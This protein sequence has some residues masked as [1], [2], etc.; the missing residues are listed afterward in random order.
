M[1]PP[2]L[3]WLSTTLAKGANLRPLS[4]D[5]LRA[6]AGSAMRVTV[7]AAYWD[8]RFLTS[9]FDSIPADRRGKATIR[10]F[11]N[12]FTGLRGDHDKK[13]L[14]ALAR[15]WH[16]LGLRNLD[17]HLITGGRLFHAKVLLFEASKEVC[18]LV[19]SANATEAAFSDN[20]EMMLMLRAAQVPPGLEQYLGE[21]EAAATPLDD[22]RPFEART[23]ASFFRMGS[24]YYK[25]TVGTQFRF[26]LRLPPAM[27]AAM[28]TLQVPIP[29]MTARASQTYNPFVEVGLSAEQE[30]ELAEF[31]EADDASSGRARVSLRNYGVQTCYGWWVPNAYDEELKRRLEPVR[32]QRSVTLDR[33]SNLLENAG[34]IIH[35]RASERFDALGKFAEEKSLP[36]PEAPGARLKRFEEF[37]QRT[38]DRVAD[39]RW[40]RRA[41]QPYVSALVP[42]IWSDPTSS[43]EF[44]DTFFDDLEFVT[45]AR[46]RPLVWRALRQELGT[47]RDGPT[48]REIKTALQAYLKNPGWTGDDWRIPRQSTRK[49]SREKA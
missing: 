37:L 40:R 41:E 5:T 45:T 16:K 34:D 44:I 26:D 9:L 29:G 43:G 14:H 30:G 46:K 33:L 47:L 2:T 36:L 11:L 1:A 31:A 35:Q 6:L 15:K 13:A 48:S 21:V 12:G 18:A 22:V 4:M 7:V 38:S 3:T 24:V 10:L 42:E 8:K 20:E 27:R 25:P 23:L 32:A 28:T 49:L 17:V 39:P 19:G